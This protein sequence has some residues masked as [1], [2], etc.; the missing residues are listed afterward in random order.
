M[1]Y[2]L[3]LVCVAAIGIVFLS[4]VSVNADFIVGWD[5]IDDGMDST[6]FPVPGAGANVSASSVMTRG[7]GINYQPDTV[8]PMRNYVS[9][10]WTTSSSPGASDYIQFVLSS[11]NPA[12]GYDL[13][14]F[15]VYG[16]RTSDGPDEF[17][18]QANTGSGFANVGAV[19]SLGGTGVVDM[20][21]DLTSLPIVSSV[22]FRLF[23]Y[24]SLAESSTAL[25][26]IPDDPDFDELGGGES[27]V[28]IIGTV[29]AVPE[30][31]AILFG[32][33]VCGAFGVAA[34]KRRLMRQGV[35]IAAA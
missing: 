35:S 34:V 33:L 17:R 1:R 18:L 6:V 7:P 16:Q 10:D 23:G 28:A 3:Q 15:R 20:M 13:T 9:S 22:T 31:S 14:Q 4:A 30:P 26:T 32:G 11:S 2:V 27:D 8:T 29:V 19:V 12:T 21:F 25:F 5:A 24:E